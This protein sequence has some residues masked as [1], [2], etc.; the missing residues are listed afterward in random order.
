MFFE[1]LALARDVAA[2]AFGD[3]VFAERFHGF[4]SDHF[5]ADG[6]LNGHFEKLARDQLFHLL[7]ERAALCLRGAA[8]KNQRQRIDRF[9]RDQHIKLN[10]IAFPVTCQVVIERSVTTRD[11]FQ[12]IVEVQHDL[13]QRQLVGQHHAVRGYVFKTLLHAAF[14]FQ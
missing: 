11:G 10:E 8:M 5:V 7:G 2:V 1:Q 14:F 9:A 13:V 12:P 4:A 6:R 3:D